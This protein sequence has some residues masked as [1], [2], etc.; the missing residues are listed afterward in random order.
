MLRVVFIIAKLFIQMVLREKIFYALQLLF[1]ILI[2]FAAYTGF[3]N[4]TLHN[5]NSQQQQQGVRK[6]WENN[7][8]KHPHRM[9][10]YGSYIFRVKHPLSFFEFGIESFTGNVIYLEA[11]K[12]NSS[13]FSQASISNGLLRFGEISLAMLWQTIL[14]LILIFIGYSSIVQQRENGTL[15]IIISQGA[16]MHQTILGNWLGLFLIAV[17]L[18]LPIILLVFIIGLFDIFK[19]ISFSSYCSSSACVVLFFIL[20]T[21]IITGVIVLISATSKQSKLALIK[22]LSC[23]L[24]FAIILP[25]GLQ[26][27]GSYLYPSP[28]KIEFN[29]K[30]EEDIIKHGDSHNPNDV[31]YKQLKDSL[32]K[33]YA[34]DSTHKLPFNYSG[35]VMREGE[36]ISAE[37]YNHHVNQL[38]ETFSK[39]NAWQINSSYIN[40]FA[41]IKQVSMNLSGTGVTDYNFF[42]QQAEAYRYKMAQAMNNLQ[43]DLISNKKLAD[44]AMPYKISSSYWKQFPN[45]HYQFFSTKQQLSHATLPS[46]ILIVWLL[47]LGII[48]KIVAQKTNPL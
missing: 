33:K 31:H 25:K 48:I 19:I 45:F 13:N 9:A 21:L 37:V 6:N 32:L 12:Q 23:W 16:T 2:A 20:F 36:R 22:L 46:I 3:A 26:A 41:A 35:V 10:H 43:I 1:Y 29:A 15:K 42:L 27:I 18:F 30:V 39:Q 4:Y 28:S 34:V 40:P 11:H 24:I 47:L 17:V 44:T 38:Q 8:D 14:P 7:P 5:T